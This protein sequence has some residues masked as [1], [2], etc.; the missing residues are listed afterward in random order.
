MFCS[1]QEKCIE[2][3]GNTPKAF[4][5]ELEPKLRQNERGQGQRNNLGIVMLVLLLPYG[6]LGNV[7]DILSQYLYSIY[8]TSHIP[9]LH[10]L[11]SP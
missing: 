11:Q 6:E 9:Y 5:N 10:R 7:S 1:S 2:H 3:M 4:Q 8:L